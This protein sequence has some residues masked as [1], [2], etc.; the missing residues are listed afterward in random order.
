MYSSLDGR[1]GG[2]PQAPLTY[3]LAPHVR[4]PGGLQM[5]ASS[6]CTELNGIPACFPDGAT[7]RITYPAAYCCLDIMTSGWYGLTSGLNAG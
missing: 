5:I 1:R 7:I 4:L 3:T 2:F 6:R